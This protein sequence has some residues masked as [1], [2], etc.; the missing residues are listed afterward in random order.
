MRIDEAPS[1]ES[2]RRVSSSSNC[3]PSS[4]SLPIVRRVSSSLSNSS[5]S[6]LKHEKLNIEKPEEIRSFAKHW[7]PKLSKIT[8]VHAAVKNIDGLMVQYDPA[9]WDTVMRVNMKGNFLFTQAFL[10]FMIQQQWGRIVHIS[11]LLG[12]IQ[13]RPGTFAYSASKASLTGMSSVLAKEY[14]RFNI[15]S[16]ILVLGYFQAGLFNTLSEDEKKRIVS[17][18]PSRKWGDISN[19]AHAIEFLIKSE[20]VNGAVINI[21]GGV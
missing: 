5:K 3:R 18:I 17:Q 11:S 1:S 6:R 13:G 9:D 21:D 2:Q 19:I 4:I 14:A 12:G 20:Y 10:P 8:I 15:T 16:N 7:G